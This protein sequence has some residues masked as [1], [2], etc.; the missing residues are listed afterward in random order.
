MSR[1]LPEHR[2]STIKNRLPAKDLKKQ[3][4]QTKPEHRSAPVERYVFSLGVP[5]NFDLRFNMGQGGVSGEADF[6]VA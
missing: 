1:A 3:G 4:M 6:H 2:L 5:A